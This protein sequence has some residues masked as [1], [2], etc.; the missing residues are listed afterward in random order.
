MESSGKWTRIEDVF[1][2][3]NGDIPLPEGTLL[4]ELKIKCVRVC[5]CVMKTI[6][7]GLR[8]QKPSALQ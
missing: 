7:G 3:E 8:F 6:L 2:V 5:L 4:K 1:P